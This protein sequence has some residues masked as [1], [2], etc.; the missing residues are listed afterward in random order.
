M[1]EVLKKKDATVDTLVK[2]YKVIQGHKPELEASLI[3]SRA[4]LSNLYITG[5]AK[6]D[7]V[8]K[9]RAAIQETEERLAACDAAL[10]E[11]QSRIEAQV[12]GEAKTEIER[13]RVQLRDLQAEKEKGREALLERLIEV[14]VLREGVSGARLNI[15]DRLWLSGAGCLFDHTEIVRVHEAVEERRA[16][17]DAIQ[18]KIDDLQRQISKIHYGLERSPQVMTSDLLK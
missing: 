3:D 10:S 11:I 8:A 1:F 7:A 16:G 18:S 9:I 6:A 15:E 4:E 14:F 12:V 13:L 5:K 17:P 2:A